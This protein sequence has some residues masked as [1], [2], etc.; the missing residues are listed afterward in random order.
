MLKS[1]SRWTNLGFQ[2]A[3]ILLAVVFTSLVLIMAGAPPLLAYQNILAGAFGSVNQVTNV[4]VAWVPL[5]LATAGLLATFSAGLWNIGIEGQITLGAIFTTGALKLLQSSSLPPA[6]VIVLAVLAGILGGALWAALAGA[7]KTFGGVNEIF[8]G[9]G[10][11]FVAT[12]LTIWLI[13]GPW[14][15]PGIGSMS[16]T[17]PFAEKFWLPQLPG[18]RL[19]LWAIGIAIVGLAL[20]YF[21]LQG[22]YFGL[23]LK[24]VGKNMRAAFLLG[25]PTTRYM[26]LSFLICGS[27]AGVVGA[28]QVVAV[29]HRLIPSI[30]SGY[31]FLGLLVAMLVN[32][33]ALWAVPVTLFFAA[34]NIGSI[35]LPIVLKLDSSLSGVL[36]GALVLFV[37]LMD[38]VRQRLTG[39]S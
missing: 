20:I 19:S 8:G 3:A 29:Y 14:K 15:C 13:F 7:L 35:Q 2:F 24:A 38:G 6:L 1:N 5:L 26:M 36:Q 11:N 30:S 22:T 18:L 34:L 39:K 10:L 32:Y 9:L 16:G 4:L 27:L 33:Q 31:G 28:I 23:R 25:I 12:A 37:L 21:L 17:E